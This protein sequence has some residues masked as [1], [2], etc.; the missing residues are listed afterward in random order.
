M[1]EDFELLFTVAKDVGEILLGKIR[2]KRIK[3]PLSFIGKI[4]QD[5]PKLY[6]VGR[7]NKLSR[8]K[9]R[10]FIHF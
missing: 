7:D 4:I 2:R 6:L 10:G 1:G 8:I 5:K 9:P 3:F